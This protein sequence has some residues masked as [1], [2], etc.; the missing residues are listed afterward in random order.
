MFCKEGHVPLSL[1]WEETYRIFDKNWMTAEKGLEPLYKRFRRDNFPSSKTEIQFKYH[2][3]RSMFLISAWNAETLTATSPTGTSLRTTRLALDIVDRPESDNL[4]KKLDSFSDSDFNFFFVDP[5]FF[6]ISLNKWDAFAQKECKANMIENEFSF[7]QMLADT[8]R[9]LHGWGLSID[10]EEFKNILTEFELKPYQEKDEGS[11]SLLD[12]SDKLTVA[13]IIAIKKEDPKLNKFEV[14]EKF[15]RSTTR[16][17]L[18]VWANA[19]EEMPAI[20]KS[21]PK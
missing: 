15:P 17:F 4:W 12:V 18:Q 5:E 21:G 16:K 20:S 1:V 14:R 6:I 7:Y 8:L 13:N 11:E 2:V 10:Q 19:S 3:G 9:P